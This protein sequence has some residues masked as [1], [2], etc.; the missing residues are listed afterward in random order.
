MQQLLDNKVFQNEYSMT[1][2]DKEIRS[3]VNP[4]LGKALD[5]CVDRSLLCVF[6][7]LFG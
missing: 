7:P 6:I 2:N 4:E 5:C 1:K 3:H